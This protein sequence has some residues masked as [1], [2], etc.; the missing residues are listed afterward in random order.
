MEG[1]GWVLGMEG[2]IMRVTTAK[3]TEMT[4]MAIKIIKAI[5]KHLCYCHIV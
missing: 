1:N 2:R 4:M 5:E 3:I